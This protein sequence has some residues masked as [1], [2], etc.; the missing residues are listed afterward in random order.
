[1]D[2]KDLRIVFMGTPEFAVGTLQSLVEEG[3]P[4]VAV[5]T[6]PDRPVGR[7][8]DRLQAPAV[9]VYAEAHHLP[10][11][12]PEKLKNPEF[13]GQL[14][15]FNANLQIV[16]AFRMLPEEVWAMP[17][18][19]TFNV[20]AALLPQYRGAA[21]INWA[22]INGETETGVTT[23]FIDK[24]IDTGRI[25]LQ[26]HLPIGVDDN[27]EKVYDGLE[28]LGAETALETIQKI[29]R[30]NGK[31]ESIPQSE[32][33]KTVGPLKAAPKIHKDTCRI[34]WHQTAKH[35]HDF[36]R[37]LS[38]VP[39]AWTTVDGQMMK[40]FQVRLTDIPVSGDQPGSLS[41][42]G[43]HLYAAG[44]DLW[45]EILELQPA[46]KRRMNAA[47]FV[48]GNRQLSQVAK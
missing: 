13:L 41:V 44:N 34:D 5:V 21:P 30:G 19:G 33:L 12:Q 16:V 4:V 47:D 46:G 1:M 35:I 10:V 18:Y 28:K 6:G 43:K 38:P 9:K 32:M 14:A 24:K 11:L 23:F 3:Y 27:V 48:N 40:I 42:D 20:H 26:K 36:V 15:A 45:I 31:A 37:G 2:K 8:Q 25:I 29:L 39:G 22:V 7:H 17:E